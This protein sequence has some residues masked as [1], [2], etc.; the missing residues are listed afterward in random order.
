MNKLTTAALGLS[1]M[2]GSAFAAAPQTDAAKPAD[3]TATS[4]ATTTKKAKKHH[5]KKAKKNAAS[6]DATAAPASK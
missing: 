3:Q 2:I 5:V 4:T 6:T 1:L